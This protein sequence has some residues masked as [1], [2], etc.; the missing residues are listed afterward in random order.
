LKLSILLD[1]ALRWTNIRSAMVG[2]PDTDGSEMSYIAG[3]LPGD[4]ACGDSTG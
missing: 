3:R 4:S 2:A 1:F